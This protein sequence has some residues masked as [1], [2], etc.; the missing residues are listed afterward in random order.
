MFPHFFCN[1]AT[2][3]ALHKRSALNRDTAFAIDYGK[4]V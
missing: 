4:E 3:R 1:F 2:E